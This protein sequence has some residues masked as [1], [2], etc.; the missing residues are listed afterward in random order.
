VPVECPRRHTALVV[1][2]VIVGCIATRVSV[3]VTVISWGGR[4]MEQAR[5]ML[6]GVDR[7]EEVASLE[8]WLRDEPE[9]R[10][11]VQR[12]PAAVGETELSGGVGEVLTVV[13]GA[14]GAAGVLA[15]SLN[16]WLRTR[17][18]TVALTVSVRDRSATLEAHNVKDAQ[19]NE[20]LKILRAV[21][22]EP[23]DE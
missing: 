10:G 6:G 4:A 12:A 8:D 14:G 16:T 9:L 5:L 3:V 11:R 15:R 7:F 17:R 2:S 13:L 20:T 23:I 21:L 18:P 22:D 19:V 1:W